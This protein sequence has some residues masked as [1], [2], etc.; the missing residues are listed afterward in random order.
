MRAQH[1]AAGALLCSLLRAP[2]TV[3]AL[4]LEVPHSVGALLCML[5]GVL[6][7]ALSVVVVG[8]RGLVKGVG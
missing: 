4:P 7:V 6:H 3:G 1:T 8:W 2:H 5:L